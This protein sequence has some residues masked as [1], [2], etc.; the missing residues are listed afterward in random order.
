MGCLQRGNK[1]FNLGL[2]SYDFMVTSDYML[3]VCL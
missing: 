1:H 2:E 3:S